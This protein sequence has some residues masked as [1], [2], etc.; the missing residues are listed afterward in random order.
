[1]RRYVAGVLENPTTKKKEAKSRSATARGSAV[2]V[3]EAP[4]TMSVVTALLCRDPLAKEAPNVLQVYPLV[5]VGR[6]LRFVEP[7]VA[8]HTSSLPCF[9]ICHL[10]SVLGTF[11][12]S[13]QSGHSPVP[14]SSPKS[15]VPNV[16]QGTMVWATAASSGEHRIFLRCA[17]FVES[18][19]TRTEKGSRCTHNVGWSNRWM[20][21]LMMENA[22]GHRPPSR[23]SATQPSTAQPA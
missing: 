10:P 15:F 5:V 16:G 2:V 9:L 12:K 3:T 7:T 14:P 17:P 21:T 4:G 18:P 11:M 19:V 23:T 8:G 6:Q 20:C 22:C 1:M 13:Q